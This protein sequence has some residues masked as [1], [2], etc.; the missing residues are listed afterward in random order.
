MGAKSPPLCVALTNDLHV[1]GGAVSLMAHRYV[2]AL[3]QAGHDATLIT[4]KGGDPLPAD[5]PVVAWD[6]PKR[7]DGVLASLSL[8]RELKQRS[9][10]AFARWMREAS[11]SG[12][13][14]NGWLAMVIPS[15]DG[16]M[17]GGG[18]KLPLLYI[19]NSPWAMEWD[20]AWES[21]HG[22]KAASW[23]RLLALAPRRRMER[24]V[25]GHARA[26]TALSQLQL[27][28]FHR[29]HPGCSRTPGFVISGAVDCSDFR[30]LSADQRRAVLEAEGIPAGQPVFLCSRRL[31]PRTGVDLLVDA[32]RKARVA[33]T[34]IV[35]GD[36]PERESLERRAAEGGSADRIRF[37]GFVDRNRLRNL[38]SAATAAV[39]PTRALEGFGL[40]AA[41]AF[42]SGTPV[43]ATPV[44]A[45]V[46]TVGGLDRRLLAT[47]VSGKA[48]T[49]AM[50]RLLETPELCSEEFRKECRNY[51]LRRFDWSHLQRGFVGLVEDTLGEPLPEH[52]KTESMAA[53]AA[54]AWD[55]VL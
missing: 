21:A 51:A 46:D 44:A 28:W 41:E 26:W 8:A 32:M 27:D 5:I 49:Q 47:E 48:L 7:G 55:D 24:R 53:E 15:A 50:A 18:E 34:L 12:R 29:E 30:P 54:A 37:L 45:L 6:Y 14:P 40:S 17:A 9:A 10:A 33:A 20:A 39:L 43:I 11:A 19:C 31:V 38:T 25:V 2:L 52:A 4:G 3:N 35:T 22:S 23:R 36:G 1:N 42:A 16:A 13:E